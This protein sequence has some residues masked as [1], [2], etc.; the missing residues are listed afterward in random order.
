MIAP[1]TYPPFRISSFA[2]AMPSTIVSVPTFALR[3]ICLMVRK[4]PTTYTMPMVRRMVNT[5]TAIV[6][7][8]KKISDLSKLSFIRKYYSTGGA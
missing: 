1:G 4:M 2:S 5:T 8:K 6:E 7:T 3:L